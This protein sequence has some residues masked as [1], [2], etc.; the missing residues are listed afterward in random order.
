MCP[1][2]KTESQCGD[3]GEGRWPR[4][5]AFVLWGDGGVFVVEAGKVGLCS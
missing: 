3:D 4:A 5:L 1:A 2:L